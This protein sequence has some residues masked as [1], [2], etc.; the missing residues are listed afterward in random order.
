ML[1]L[2][3]SEFRSLVVGCAC[4]RMLLFQSNFLK[5]SVQRQHFSM[6]SP[7]QVSLL[8]DNIQLILDALRSSTVVEVQV[9]SRMK[10]WVI[11]SSLIDQ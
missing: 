3:L 1:M 6:A 9:S 2:C 5:L 7:F 11:C 8:T 4:S 10:S